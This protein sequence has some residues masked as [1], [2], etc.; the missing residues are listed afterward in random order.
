MV[1]RI[2]ASVVVVLSLGVGVAYAATQVASS[3]GTQVCV[4]EG[5]GLVRVAATCRA[6]EY[7]LTIGGGS[8]VAVTSSGTVTV[9]LGTSSTPVT[10]PVTGLTLTAVC[11]RT[12]APVPPYSP[13]SA[14]ARVTIAAPTGTMDVITSLPKGGGAIGLAGT[15]GGTSLTAG[16]QGA[17][18]VGDVN[19]GEGTAIASANGA[20]AS[21]TFGVQ[22]SE[23]DRA[24]KFISQATEAP[25]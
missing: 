4:N 20:T 25:N 21:I 19:Y 16:I 15:V 22:V 12:T 2:I 14:A 6:G 23:P 1:K 13:N 10:L 3:D 7:P 17:L 8:D 9:A 18:S 5:R 11:E 24:C